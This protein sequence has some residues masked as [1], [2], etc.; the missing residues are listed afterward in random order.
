MDGLVSAGTAVRV[1]TWFGDGKIA[2]A[3]EAGREGAAQLGQRLLDAQGENHLPHV[4]AG[5]VVGAAEGRY[6]DNTDEHMLE[7]RKSQSLEHPQ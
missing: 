6:R 1:I 2:D 7:Q 4:F 5:Y 3:G